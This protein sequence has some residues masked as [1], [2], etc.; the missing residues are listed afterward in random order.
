[1]SKDTPN[2]IKRSGIISSILIL[3]FF[4]FL[5]LDA[6]T[7]HSLYN[8]WF[9][10]PIVIAT[11]L[12]FMPAAALLISAITFAYWSAHRKQGF[13]KSIFDWRHNWTMLTVVVLSLGIIALALGHDSVHCVVNNPVK[14]IRNWH[15]TW[16]CI[17]QD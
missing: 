5:T 17:K 6:I 3:P 15:T 7:S 12:V 16:T 8:S 9:W 4:I 10:Q 14:E 11:W 13:W 1:M 2:Y